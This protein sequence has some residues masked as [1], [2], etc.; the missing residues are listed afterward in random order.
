MKKQALPY[1]ELATKSVSEDFKE[2]MQAFKE[3]RK[4]VFK[5]RE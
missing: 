1:L 2:G 5:G 3:K 4:P